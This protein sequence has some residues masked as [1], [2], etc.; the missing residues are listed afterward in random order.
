[1]ARVAVHFGLHPLWHDHLTGTIPS[2]ACSPLWH[3]ALSGTN[4]TVGFSYVPGPPNVILQLL[5]LTQDIY[6]R[7]GRQPKYSRPDAGRGWRHAYASHG[8]SLVDLNLET[9][10]ARTRE[11]LSEV[12][13]VGRF[14][15]L[16]YSKPS[17]IR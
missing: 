4:G 2:L 10:M 16:S 17:I 11:G 3:D 13:P 12:D 14:L 5:Y 6:S 8:S 1:V 9:N 15:A 7:M